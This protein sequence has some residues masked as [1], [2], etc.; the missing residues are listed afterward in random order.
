MI[1]KLKHTF[2]NYEFFIKTNKKFEQALNSILYNKIDEYINLYKK[3]NQLNKDDYI[4][5]TDKDIKID[6]YED[7]YKVMLNIHIHNYVKVIFNFNDF[8]NNL[9]QILNLNCNSI[10]VFEKKENFKE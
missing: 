3:Y 1:K 2:Y 8:I 10:I 6:I 9:Y 5:K 7:G 4:K